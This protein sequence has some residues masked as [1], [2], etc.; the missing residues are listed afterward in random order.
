MF[1][2]EGVENRGRRLLVEH[3]N[4]GDVVATYSACR[5][6]AAE[7]TIVNSN[8][9]GASDDIPILSLVV[10]D[11]GIFQCAWIFLDYMGILDNLLGSHLISDAHFV[12]TVHLLTDT[13]YPF[14]IHPLGESSDA[15]ACLPCQY[16][17]L[18]RAF[19]DFIKVD[20]LHAVKRLFL[21][22]ERVFEL[23]ENP[24]QRIEHSVRMNVADM[25]VVAGIFAKGGEAEVLQV[26]VM[27]FGVVDKSI[28]IP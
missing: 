7:E 19:Y 6:D 21:F 20:S 10:L 18:A 8:I 5:V 22:Q 13:S 16:G 27:V 14:G 2:Q 28:L 23:I 26:L 15:K 9:S 24:H 1:L 11:S 17:L 3:Q 4:V 25:V 12:G